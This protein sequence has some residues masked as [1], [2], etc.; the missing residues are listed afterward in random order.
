MMRW[1]RERGIEEGDALVFEHAG[2]RTY[3]LTLEKRSRQA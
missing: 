1:C 2:E 3:R